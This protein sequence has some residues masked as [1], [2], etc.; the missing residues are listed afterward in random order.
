[1]LECTIAA[2]LWCTITAEWQL[3][4]RVIWVNLEGGNSLSQQQQSKLSRE[5]SSY[6]PG[7]LCTA[8]YLLNCSINW[9]SGCGEPGGSSLLFGVESRVCRM[10]P[11][12]RAFGSGL[13]G[14]QT[15]WRGDWGLT[16]NIGISYFPYLDSDSGFWLWIRFR[17]CPFNSSS[18]VSSAPSPSSSPLSHL[19]YFDRRLWVHNPT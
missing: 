14:G 1:V 2:I 9:S 11:K 12:A 10:A 17:S 7:G 8:R 19:L 3:Y 4:K 6:G 18:I 16:L 5:N 13:G 15:G